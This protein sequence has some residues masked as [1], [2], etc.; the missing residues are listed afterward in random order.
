M[1]LSRQADRDSGLGSVFARF[2][3][4]SGRRSVCWIGKHGSLF[5]LIKNKHTLLSASKITV[6][7]CSARSCLLGAAWL[8]SSLRFASFLFVV[9]LFVCKSCI[10]LYVYL[11]ISLS[12]SI[13]L[14]FYLLFILSACIQ[15]LSLSI[16]FL[17]LPLVLFVRLSPPFNSRTSLP[18]FLS[19]LIFQHTLIDCLL[20]SPL[21]LSPPLSPLFYFSPSLP[22]EC[23]RRIAIV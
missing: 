1:F 19:F 17:V 20:R 21:S 8:F 6:V 13:C 11:S 7:V 2:T 5:F 4:I 10:S 3:C 12:L 22:P 18:T 14:S 16:Y 23:Q 9:C 15:L